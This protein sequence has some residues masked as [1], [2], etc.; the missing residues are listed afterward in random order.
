MTAYA[1]IHE[2]LSHQ[3]AERP[4][5][6]CLIHEE[7]QWTYAE[8]AAEVERVA[9]AFAALGLQPGQRVAI[10]LPNCSEFLCTVFAMA[11]TGGVFVPLNTAQTADELRYLLAHSEARY[12]L[13]SEAFMP[14]IQGIRG[15]CPE[16]EQVVTLDGESTDGA[17]GWE[18]FIRGAARAPALTEVSPEDMASIIYTSGTTDRPKGVMLQHFAFAFAPSNRARALGWTGDDRV[19]VVMPLFHVNAL[20]HMTLAMLSV[21]GGVVLKERFSASRFWDDVKCH[22]VTTSSIMQTIPRI[23]LNLPPD[24]GDADT[25]LRQ[26][27]ALLPPDVH[28]EF[29]RR[30]GVTAIPTYSLTE[31]LLSVLGPLDVSRRK[32]GSCGVPIAPDVHRVRIVND[33]GE[34]CTSG[35]LGEIVKQSPAVMMGYYKNPAATAAALRD[36]WLHTG[37]LGY[38]DEDRFLYFV[39]RKKDIIKRGGENI[40]SAEVERVLNSHPLIAESA[41]VAVP[42]LIRQEEVK[43]CVVLAAGVPRED[44]PPERLWQFCAERLAAFKVPR[45]L[46]Y[47]PELPKTPSSKVQ[48]NLL[49]DEGVG[50]NVM[51]RMERQDILR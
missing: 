19:L 31:D 21:G 22:G 44:L 8:L 14:L 42:D 35:Q 50:P 37:D 39:D 2:L 30:F 28:L 13:T 3:A 12:L 40:A 43:A 32:L 27:M 47:R 38:L 20:C 24:P 46:D 25:P 6:P 41:A 16:L 5:Q 11:R 34:N 33:E 4:D 10:L 26:V 45:Y 48:K 18:E 49:R 7:R 17:L 9:R 29:E 23:L 36:G 15:D 51:D 1:T